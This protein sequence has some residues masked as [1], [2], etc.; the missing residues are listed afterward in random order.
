MLG[1]YTTVAVVNQRK[2]KEHGFYTYIETYVS[3][4]FKYTFVK[5]LVRGLNNSI[6]QHVYRCIYALL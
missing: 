4:L 6:A 3:A 5:R 2:E 1:M